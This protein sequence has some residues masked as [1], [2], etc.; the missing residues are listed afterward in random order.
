VTVS[1]SPDTHAPPRPE[2][3]SGPAVGTIRWVASHP[4]W[5]PL[6][7]LAVTCA[8]PWLGVGPL[9]IRLVQLVAIFTLIVSGTNLSF[10]YA[11]ELSFAQPAIYAVGAYV[12]G[13]AAINGSND[14]LLALIY[15][16]AAAALAGLVIGIPGL[17]LSSWSLAMVSFFVVLLVPDLIAVLHRWTGGLNDLVGIPQPQLFGFTLSINQFYVACILVMA[18]WLA[19]MRN[20]ILSRHGL[21]IGVLRESPVLAQ[22]LGISVFAMKLKIYVLGSISAGFAGVLFAYYDQILTPGIFGFSV[23]IAVIAACI[24]GG[25]RS[26]YGAVIG[27]AIIQI[28]PFEFTS[29]QSYSLIVYGGLLLLGGLLVRNGITSLLRSG[30]ELVLHRIGAEP[31][32]AEPEPEPPTLGDQAPSPTVDAVGS[33]QI[34]DVTRHF[35]GVSALAGVSLTAEAGQVTAI[36][37]PNGSGKTTLLNIVSGFYAPS[38]GTVELGGARLGRGR[39]FRS[40]R[41]GVSRTFQTPIVPEGVTTLEAVASARYRRTYVTLP[42]SILRLGRARRTQAADVDEARRALDLVGISHVADSIASE[43]PLGTRRLVEVARAIAMEPRVLLLDEPASGLSEAEVGELGRVVRTLAGRGVV[44][45]LVEHNFEFV[46]RTADMIYVLALG[47]LLAS[48][49]PEDIREDPRVIESYLG[50]STHVHRQGAPTGDGPPATPSPGV[51]R[52]EA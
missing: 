49:G 23:A 35:G 44:V 41:N 38:S 7:A 1:P 9:W 24:L 22:S 15:G 52:S 29:F 27:A 32:L 37:G 42:S 25:S 10:G 39:A 17:R 12:G 28:G 36:I 31:R 45:I 30:V 18:G 21:A 51:L 19:F 2:G 13:Y 48:G 33:L 6:V 11:G 43:L 50:S 20:L 26:I 4:Q 47:A 46:L 34:R 16:G 5:L 14:L 40:A 8:L 3:G